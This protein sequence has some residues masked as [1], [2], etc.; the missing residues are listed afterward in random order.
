MNSSTVKESTQTILNNMKDDPILELVQVIAADL[1]DAVLF[2][3]YK[4]LIFREASEIT[5]TAFRIQARWVTCDDQEYKILVR[6][7]GQLVSEIIR[8][9]N[10]IP[11]NVY[12]MKILESYEGIENIAYGKSSSAVEMPFTT[13]KTSYSSLIVDHSTTQ[14]LRIMDDFML[15]MSNHVLLASLRP[16]V[17]KNIM[18]VIPFTFIAPKIL[19]STKIAPGSYCIQTSQTYGYELVDGSIVS[20]HDIV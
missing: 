9:I 1:N 8:I 3:R 5:T 7:L 16:Q 12:S 15:S 19:I 18:S 17:G 13:S 20:S 2:D 6:S 11:S 4:T 10:V 14:A